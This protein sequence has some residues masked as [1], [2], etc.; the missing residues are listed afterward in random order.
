MAAAQKNEK[1]G[2][3]ME[4]MTMNDVMELTGLSW[5]KARKLVDDAK[6]V[7]K[8]GQRVL[9]LSDK[10]DAYLHEQAEG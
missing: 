6:A 4:C 9:I 8:V 10:L 3:K 2:G 7:V 1:G 5:P